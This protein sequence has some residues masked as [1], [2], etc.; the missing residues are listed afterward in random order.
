MPRPRFAT[1][2]ASLKERILHAAR[3]EFARNGYEG[4]SLNRILL[5]AGLSKGAYY[6]YFDDKL[7]LAVTVLA[8]EM[9]RAA[10]RWQHMRPMHDA[11]GFWAELR[12]FS[13]EQSKLMHAERTRYD[14]LMRLSSLLKNPETSQRLMGLVK[15]NRP[16]AQELMLKGQELG[17]VRTDLPVHAL[18]DLITNVKLSLFRSLYP[19]DRVLSEPELETFTDQ[20][21]ALTK[22]LLRP[23]R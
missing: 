21:L 14:C 22:R 5:A 9:V 16:H 19:D 6:Y 18:I 4:A 1:A 13:L 7:D 23:E 20:V 12:R 3:E 11:D 10:E 2:D 8:E 17:A 15:I